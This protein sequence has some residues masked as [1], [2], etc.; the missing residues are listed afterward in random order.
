[1]MITNVNKLEKILLVGKKSYGSISWMYYRAFKKM[2]HNVKIFDDEALYFKNS[3]ARNKYFHYFFWKILA[4]PLQKEF[5]KTVRNEKPDLILVLKGWFFKPETLIKIKKENPQ[6]KLFCFN[7]DNPFN[8]WHFSNSNDWIIK[9]IPIYDCYFIW[10]KFLIEPLKKVGAKKV[11]YLPFAHD[12]ELHYPIKVNEKE[13]KFYG[14]DIA[15]IGTWDEER[16]ELLN[17]LLDYNLKIWGN[18][19]EK[20]NK[21]LQKKWMKRTAIGEEF[22]KVCNSSKII[23]NLIRKQNI[24]AHNMRTFEVPACKGFV[25][26][27]RTEEVLEFFEEGKEIEC[28][29]TIKELKEKIDY[30]LDHEKERKKIVEAGYKRLINSKHTYEERAKKILEI[31]KNL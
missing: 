12:P 7:G 3:L 16:E 26:S 25:L 9:S 10:G 21:K 18:S 24:P 23:L 14:S 20:A 29:S 17:N 15:F 6:T 13:K 2:V 5:I 30:Y 1:M 4:S 8:T 28:F 27:T 11:E 19:W 22:S 31:Y